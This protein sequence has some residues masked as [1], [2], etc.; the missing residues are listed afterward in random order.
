[1]TELVTSKDLL[2]FVALAKATPETEIVARED[3]FVARVKINGAF[4]AVAAIVKG[5]TLRE[6]EFPTINAASAFLIKANIRQFK[7]DARGAKPAIDAR[8]PANRDRMR[9]LHRDAKY[10]EWLRK[11]IQTSRADPRP[12]IP[13]EAAQAMFDA[14]LDRLRAIHEAKPTQ[15]V[16]RLEARKA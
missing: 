3:K 1:M 10:L 6:R 14:H 16:A 2:D 5:K 12:S 11:E 7:I 13:H 9:E 8:A 15:A 4:R